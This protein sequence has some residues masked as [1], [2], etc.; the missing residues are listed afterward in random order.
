M[1][2]A[3]Q[4]PPLLLLHGTGA[5]THTWAGLLP[6][7][8]DKFTIIAPDLPGQGFTKALDKNCFSMTGM[9]ESLSSL[10]KKLKFSPAF[11]IGHSAGA[12]LL[13]R[14]TLDARIKPLSMISI[15]GAFFPFGG[16]LTSFFAPLAK[17][18]ALNPLVPHLF[19][20]GAKDRSSVKRLLSST[21]SIIPETSLD[22]YQRL[23]RCPSHVSSTLAMM[24]S[25]DL[26]TLLK[27]IPKLS[28]PLLLVVGEKD[29]TI[30]A[31]DG[32]RLTTLV[33]GSTLEQLQNLGHLAH[34]E[35]PERVAQ[36]IL[37]FLQH[38]QPR[39][40]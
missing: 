39:N 4:G 38:M 23:F 32:S 19:T 6:L 11:C 35:D 16:A 27:D 17:L 3:G 20:W 37:R 26:E 18:L 30:P 33:H 22:L 9:A 7:L 1:Q 5:S 21:G 29:K 14:M 15:N 10:L 40:I 8:V 36:A 24:A 34:E 12:A 31:E 25:W 13:V 28:V 2:I